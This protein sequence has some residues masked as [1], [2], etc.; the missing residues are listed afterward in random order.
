M[1]TFAKK[2]QCN[3]C[4]R[5]FNRTDS[6]NRH[7]KI[8]N[9]EIEEI[10]L[11]GKF[12]TNDTLFERLENW[13]IKIKVPEED[14]YYRYISTYDFEAIQVPDNDFV[15]GRSMHSVHVAATFSIASNIPGHTEPVHEVSD[16]NP[17]KLDDKM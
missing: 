10:Y 7:A 6:L 9:T 15:H 16:G 1:D 5:I 3:I 4:D 8:C 12:K 14:R 17:Q 11:G 13:K 2:Y